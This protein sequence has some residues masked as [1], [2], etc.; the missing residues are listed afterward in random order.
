MSDEYNKDPINFYG[1]AQGVIRNYY[2]KDVAEGGTV[3]TIPLG[4]HWA[5]P[6]GEP[7]VHTP[8]PPFREFVWSFVGTGWAGRR[9]KLL[10]LQQVPGDHKLVFMDEWNSPSMLGRE[11]TLSILLNSWFVPC[12]A[13]NNGETFRIY[14]ALEAGAVPIVVQEAGMEDYFTFIGRHLPLMLATSWEHAAQLVYTLKSQP[15]LYEKYRLQLLE[16][17][18]NCKLQTNATV[19]KVFKLQ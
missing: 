4:F 16:A 14:E 5:I 10:A 18:E 6:N 13:G 7:A 9:D 11:E 17:W 19:K 8:R 2:R 3:V 15:E 12:P 1:L